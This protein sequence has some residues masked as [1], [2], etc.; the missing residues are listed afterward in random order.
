MDPVLDMYDNP[1]LK[2]NKEPLTV[3]DV[4]GEA[5]LANIEKEDK[6]KSYL[7]KEE[8]YSFWKDKIKPAEEIEFTAEETVLIKKRVSLV[9]GTLIS[10]QISS[11][12]LSK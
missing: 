7:E 6:D 12:Y 2:P 3:K 11:Q 10:G 5:L 9:Y 8:L 4:I 1:I